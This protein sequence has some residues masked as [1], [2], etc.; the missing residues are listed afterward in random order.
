MLSVPPLAVVEALAEGEADEA[1]LLDAV[2]GED[3]VVVPEGEAEGTMAT[4]M[5]RTMMT[6]MA[7]QGVAVVEALAAAAQG[8][9]VL[10][11]PGV[12]ARAAEEEGRPHRLVRDPG[13]EKQQV[14][15]RTHRCRR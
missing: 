13:N 7:H 6:V 11:R 4:T 5:M 1:V 12:Q 14:C 2:L 3:V 8:H 15:V 10:L 9:A